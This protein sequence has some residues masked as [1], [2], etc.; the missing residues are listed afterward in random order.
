MMGMFTSTEES[1]CFHEAAHAVVDYCQEAIIYFIE[2]GPEPYA[3]DGVSAGR[4]KV[5]P[6]DSSTADETMRS[7]AAGCA[8]D[9]AMGGA[10]P[11][12]AFQNASGDF[13]ALRVAFESKYSRS[14]NE[15]ELAESFVRGVELATLFFRHSNVANATNAVGKRLVGKLDNG[16]ARMEREEFEEILKRHIGR[17]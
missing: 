7:I 5:S 4:V 11:E 14:L 16:R 8:W 1:T 3:T 17:R 10:E 12:H 15:E 13:D 6:L 9:I 2:I